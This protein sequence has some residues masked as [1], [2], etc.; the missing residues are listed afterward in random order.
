MEIKRVSKDI[1]GYRL[2]LPG[3]QKNLCFHTFYLNVQM[4]KGF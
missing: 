2:F 3:L 1:G 4:V